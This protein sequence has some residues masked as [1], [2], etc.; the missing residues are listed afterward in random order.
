MRTK[1]SFLRAYRRESEE[2]KAW[3]RKR[4]EETYKAALFP[5]TLIFAE[6]RLRWIREEEE[7]VREKKRAAS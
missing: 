5:E 4:L 2:G 1:E 7:R 6:F 3:V